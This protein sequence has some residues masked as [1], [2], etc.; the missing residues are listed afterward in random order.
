MATRREML[1]ALV[2]S[3]GAGVVVPGLAA[4]DHFGRHL[5]SPGAIE[6]ADAKAKAAAYK[7]EFL[8]PH[9]FATVASLAERIVPGAARAKTTEFIDQLLA[10]DSPDDQRAFL[11]ALG[12][13][14][15]QAIAG[16]S[17]PWIQLADADQIAILTSASEMA[18]SRPAARSWTKGDPIDVGREPS[19]PAPLTLR[20]HFDLLKSWVAGAY[21]S[22]EIGMKELG[23]TGN[24]VHAAF[25]GCDHPDSHA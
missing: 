25:P 1:H 16:A 12:A 3:L 2:A 21:Y 6:Q 23:W 5:S 9:Q 15:G 13:F 24:V 17:R 4:Q 8:D 20:D 7:P 18:S 11:T 14:E 19:A 10:A 22:S